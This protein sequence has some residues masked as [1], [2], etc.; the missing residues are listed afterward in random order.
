MAARFLRVVISFS[1]AL[2]P[3]GVVA[4]SKT[5]DWSVSLT[6]ILCSCSFSLSIGD[7]EASIDEGELEEELEA[8]LDGDSE[9]DEELED[10]TEA[11]LVDI[12]EYSKIS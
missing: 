5:V 6:W 7:P 1:A 4:T 11:E 10:G 8:E 3:A 12:P 9:L 2:A